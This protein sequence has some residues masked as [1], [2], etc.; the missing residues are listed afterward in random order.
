MH[1]YF[2]KKF[3]NFVY[4]GIRSKGFRFFYRIFHLFKVKPNRILFASD[5]HSNLDGNF[6]FI[7]SELIKRDSQLDIRFMLKSSIGTKKT[8]KELVLLAYYIATARFIIIDD[9]YPMIYPLKIRSGADLIQVWHAVGAF[10]KFG[11]SR[12]EL[13]GNQLY[14]SLYHKNY[15]KVVV[16]SQSVVKHY[17]EGFGISKDKIYPIGI[18][19][20][21][22][23]FDE[24]YKHLKRKELLNRYP[25]IKNK[26]VILF[27]PTFRGN[28]QN[29]A[30]YPFEQL[31]LKLLYEKLNSEYIFFF[32]LHPFITTKIDIPAQYQDFF[33][34]H[35]K[36]DINELL[37]IT[38]ILITDYSSVCFE[39][40]LFDKPMMFYAFDLG[41]YKYQRDFYFDYHSFIP[42]NMVR[43]MDEMV[44]KIIHGD[45]SKEKI[46]DFV[47]Y[48]YDYK[49]GL[50]SKRFVEQLIIQKL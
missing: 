15:T 45:F 20:T 12:S 7:Y 9:F 26:K 6:K 36:Q 29:S 32:K 35:F 49:D 4:R 10:K 48:F 22:V 42:G 2:K 43:T 31:D 25:Y 34:D 5:S 41:E 24:Q 16:S 28:G 40:A 50:S 18:P 39:F 23:F 38:D 14:T 33:F 13:P 37:F 30:Y 11:F 8:I 17:A 19:R 3:N 44:E 1:N 27:A 46:K 47:D 21:D